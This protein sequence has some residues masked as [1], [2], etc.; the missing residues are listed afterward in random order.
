MQTPICDFARQYLKSGFSRLHM[1]GHKGVPF[2]GPEPY[3]LTEIHGADSLYEAAGIIAQS[4]Q[5]ATALFGTKRTLYSTEGSSQCIKAMLYL[6]LLGANRNGERPVVLAAR[7][8]H[9]SFLS[10]CALL[11]VDVEWLYPQGDV[12]SICS[13]SVGAAALEEAL[14]QMS[15]PPFAVFVTSPDY[16]GGMLDLAALSVVCHKHGVPLLVDNAHGAYLKF[17]STSLHPMDLGADLCCDSAHKTLPVL[18]GGAYL[19]LA[20]QVPD[21]WAAEAKHAMALFGSTS[22]SY[23][24]LQSLDLCNRVLSEEYPKTLAACM[25]RTGRLK[26][27][28]AQSGCAVLETEPLKLVFDAQRMGMSGFALASRLREHRVECEYCDADDVVLMLS[29]QNTQKDFERIENAMDGLTVS[30]TEKPLIPAMFPQ[31]NAAMTIRQAVFAKHETLPAA[32]SLGRVCG[33]LTVACPPA[34]PIVVC[35]EV[36]TPQTI[37]LFEHYGIRSV[38]V[39][40]Q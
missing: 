11:D 21:S 19:H 2:L 28:L 34:I 38:E 10:A 8:A 32:Q 17:L 14:S 15:D 29:P 4:E 26:T 9:R 39:V 6:A 33:M 40:A 3:D 25:E 12:T 24:V 16:L 1:P 30:E 18:T 13:C 35:G 36:I 5:N 20:P 31:A 23:L 7:N 27:S 22:P 37:T